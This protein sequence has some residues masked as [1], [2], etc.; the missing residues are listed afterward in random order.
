M[1]LGISSAVVDNVPLMA[2]AQNMYDLSTFPTDHPFW[3]ML[4]YTTGTGGS[5]LIIGSAA[6]VAAMGIT[7]INFGWYLKNVSVWVLLGYL[8]GWLLLSMTLGS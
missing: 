1:I 3:L 4:A 5:L 8:S 2:A 6:G 7:K